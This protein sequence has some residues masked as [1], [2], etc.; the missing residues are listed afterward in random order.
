M[1]DITKTASALIVVSMI[2]GFLTSATDQAT[3]KAIEANN[4][5]KTA[6]A[7]TLIFPETK[8]FVE[9]AVD[10]NILKA[11]NSE[12]P[13]KTERVFASYDANGKLSG[14]AF[15]AQARGFIDNVVVLYGYNPGKECITGFS[16]LA[17]KETKGFGDQIDSG[18][19]PK[20]VGFQKNFKCL[21]VRMNPEKTALLNI[22]KMTKSGANPDNGE[23]DGIAGSTITSKAM[24]KMLIA[25]TEKII[26]M[27]VDNMN[28]L[29]RI[30]N[31]K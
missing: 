17:S 4:R 7:V 16:V 6:N 21:S 3:R 26:P 22:I 9:F 30:E 10:G 18:K 28:V 19:T 15:Q 8:N 1:N 29:K 5:A 31:G 25:S 14:I 27:I 24:E 2:C 20:S 11:V 12:T 23:F 13:K